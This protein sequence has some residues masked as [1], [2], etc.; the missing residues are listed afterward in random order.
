M[1]HS[2][3]SAAPI[4]GPCRCDSE[5]I[6]KAEART[7]RLIATA[8]PGMLLRRWARGFRELRREV[9]KMGAKRSEGQSNRKFD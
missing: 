4:Q 6:G 8:R 5:A 9:G 7:N 2:C 1:Q 3:M